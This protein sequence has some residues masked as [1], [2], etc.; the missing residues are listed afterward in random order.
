MIL[1]VRSTTLS[2]TTITLISKVIVLHTIDHHHVTQ[3][4][5]STTSVE[6]GNDEICTSHTQYTQYMAAARPAQPLS[7]RPRPSV[8]RTEDRNPAQKPMWAIS[9]AAHGD[10]RKAG[11]LFTVPK[12]YINHKLIMTDF[13]QY[14]ETLRLPWRHLQHV[15]HDRTQRPVWNIYGINRYF[16]FDLNF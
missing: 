6:C 7:R 10:T 13:T 15:E 14:K 2:T 11:V 16:D 8:A 12:S 4:G 3:K 9:W 1:C 5:T